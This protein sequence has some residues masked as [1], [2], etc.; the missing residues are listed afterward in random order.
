MGQPRHR[1]NPTPLTRWTRM[2]AAP[3]RDWS[4]FQP[5]FADPWEA[6]QHTH[7]RYQTPYYDGLVAKMLACSHPEKIGDI[8]YRCR[9]CGQGK[10]L[11]A[12]RGKSSRCL[13]GAKVSVDNWGS[14]VSQALHEGVLSRHI[15]LTVP[16]MFRTTFSQNAAVVLRA[17][18]RGG[19]P[20]LED[21]SRTVRGQTLQGGSITVRHTHGRHGPYPPH[22]PGLATR[23]G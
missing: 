22:R 11:V 14:Q 21:F 17:F 19:A 12:M 2:L 23:G 4:V 7:P 3:T 10:H 9:H 20:C 5:I 18:M 16:A 13:R 6:F 15:I 1:N 8:E